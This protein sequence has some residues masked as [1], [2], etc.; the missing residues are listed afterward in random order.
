[1]QYMAS[2]VW[3]DVQHLHLGSSHAILSK[4]SLPHDWCVDAGGC[5][6]RKEKKSYT[7]FQQVWVNEAGLEHQPSPRMVAVGSKSTISQHYTVL[8][9][10]HYTIYL[11]MFVKLLQL[12]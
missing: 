1:M 11:A 5:G 3:L 10:Y 7:S 12:A 6:K 9:S 8:C 2:W 4:A